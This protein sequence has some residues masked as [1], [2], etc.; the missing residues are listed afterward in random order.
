MAPHEQNWI[1]NLQLDFVSGPQARAF[2]GYLKRSPDHQTSRIWRLYLTLD[3]DDYIEINET[4]DLLGSVSLE[5][6][7]NPVGGTIVWVKRSAILRRVGAESRQVQADFLRGELATEFLSRT[8]SEALLSVPYIM[9]PL[10]G[11]GDRCTQ[12]TVCAPCHGMTHHCASRALCE[13][14]GP[15]F[16]GG[17][18]VG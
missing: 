6:P 7:Q 2:F 17:P 5:T 8:G 18:Q 1:A 4:T 13:R 15:Q 11:T 10:P 9:K 16:E 3:F 12:I 14:G